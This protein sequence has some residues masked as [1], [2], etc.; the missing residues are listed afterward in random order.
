MQLILTSLAALSILLSTVQAWT[1]RLHLPSVPYLPQYNPSALPCTTHATLFKMGTTAEALLKRDN[2]MEFQNLEPGSYLLTITTLDWAFSP[3][4][5]DVNTSSVNAEGKPE[6][7]IDAWQTFYGNEWGNKGEYRGG[8]AVALGKQDDGAG[9]I[10]VELKPNNKKE[11]FM[12]RPGF[13]PAAFLRNP[14]ILMALFSLVMIV[15]LPYLME[16][17]EYQLQYKN[18]A[19]H[20]NN[21][22]VDEDTKAEFEE[23]QK[24]GGGVKNPAESIQNFDLA[25]WMAGKSTASNTQGNGGGET[26]KRK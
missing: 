24:S 7:R 9:V 15:G 22:T 6:V 13:S 23:M 11:Y 10:D 2:T 18:S 19:Q 12:E 5:V 17:S 4:R 20:T 25:G 8:G 26:S 21:S 3:S 1:L 16:N 14:M